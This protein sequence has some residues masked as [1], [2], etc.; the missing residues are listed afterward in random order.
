M[1]GSHTGEFLS[2]DLRGA[3]EGDEVWVRSSHAYEGTGIGYEFTG[4]AAGDTI[5]GMVD[6]GEY[7]KGKFTA[8]RH[9]YGQRAR[10]A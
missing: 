2:A 10:K 8:R 6:V 9:K 3:V 5:T 7:G 4:K 1:M